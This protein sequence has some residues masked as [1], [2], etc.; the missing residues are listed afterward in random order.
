M[1]S[2]LQQQIIN[3]YQISKQEAL[4]LY[5]EAD[6]EPLCQAA[7]Q[8]RE[9]YCGN[10][11]DICTIIN[12]KS[13][14]CTEDCKY[15]AQS[16]HYQ[17]NTETYPL[18]PVQDVVEQAIYNHDKG[19]LRFSIVTSGRCLNDEEIKQVCHNYQQIGQSCS[20]LLCASHGL[21][22]KEQLTQLK[23]AGVVRYHNNLETSRRFFPSLCTTHSYA[24]KL[25]T[26]KYAQQVGLNVCSGGIMGMGETVTDRIDL[27]FALKELGIRSVPINIFSPIPG[28]PLAHLPILSNNEFCRIVAVFRF[29][30]PQAALRLAG[31]R[32]LLPD[33]GRRVFASGANAA[34]SGDML[35]TEGISIEQDMIMLKSLGYEVSAL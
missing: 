27:A 33:K 25:N 35:T 26:I 17:V 34:I 24:D 14:K 2:K 22:N 3:G 8:I 15:C 6:L 21:L 30:L 10:C 11:F 23:E 28:T 16:A 12:G 32:G 7:N 1:I 9:F 5:E 31:G 4:Q 13:G 29:I 20:I 19:V 18:L